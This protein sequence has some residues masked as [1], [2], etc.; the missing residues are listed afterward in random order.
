[1]RLKKEKFIINNILLII[2]KYIYRSFV[3]HK[4][5]NWG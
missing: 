4:I 5:F 2:D 3:F 1:M